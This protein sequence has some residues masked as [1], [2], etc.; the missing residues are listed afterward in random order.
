M[1]KE[2]VSGLEVDELKPQSRFYIEF[3]TNPFGK[4]IE[5]PLSHSMG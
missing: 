2:L 5:P 1:A 4:V 3:P